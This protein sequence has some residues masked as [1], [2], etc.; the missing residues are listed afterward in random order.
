MF[1]F[2]IFASHTPFLIM[3]GLYLFYMLLNIGVKFNQAV[4]DDMSAGE[5]VISQKDGA[6]H[7]DDDSLLAL[8]L[9]DFQKVT[10]DDAVKD[11]VAADPPEPGLLLKRYLYRDASIQ[12]TPICCLF[13]RPPPVKA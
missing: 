1:S 10:T 2:G 7:A 5:K 12:R 4:A 13:A 9:E 3:A 11:A 8:S 6:A